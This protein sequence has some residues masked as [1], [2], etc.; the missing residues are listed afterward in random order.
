LMGLE[1]EGQYI[2][3]SITAP[4]PFILLIYNGTFHNGTLQNGALKGQSSE[5]LTP[6]FNIF[7]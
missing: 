5:I 6:F 1:V 7:G 4:A 3:S 2:R